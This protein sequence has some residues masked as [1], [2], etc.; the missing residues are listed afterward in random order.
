VL[1]LLFGT[2]RIPN[3][4]K[5]FGKGI[6]EFKKALKDDEKDSSDKK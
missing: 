4:T 3:I 5:N 2:K 6:K 1:F